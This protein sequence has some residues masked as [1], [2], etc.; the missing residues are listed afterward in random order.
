MLYHI[1]SILN[2][3]SSSTTGKIPNEVAYGFSPHRPLNFLSSL[4]V[5]DTYSSCIE[6]ADTILFVLAN[7]KA[8]YDQK[9]QSLFMKVRDW[10]M[11]KLHKG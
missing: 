6:A 4:I 5:L 11:L 8:H 1:Q 3:I 9:H 10:A 7:Q 2:N